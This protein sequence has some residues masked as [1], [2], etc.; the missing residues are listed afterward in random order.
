MNI[1]IQALC[2]Y[3]LTSWFAWMLQRDVKGYQ[4]NLGPVIQPILYFLSTLGRIASVVFLIRLF[5]RD[6]FSWYEPITIALLG[7]VINLIVLTPLH[8]IITR[9][10]FLLCFIAHIV[11]V[12]GLIASVILQAFFFHSIP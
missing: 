1:Y 4:G 5:F 9:R 11:S 7:E 12:L 6:S 8:A 10:N 2:I 3:S